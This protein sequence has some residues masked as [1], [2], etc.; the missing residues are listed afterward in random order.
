MKLLNVIWDFIKTLICCVVVLALY[1]GVGS[2]IC[3]RLFLD[4]PQGIIGYIIGAAILVMMLFHVF[5][6]IYA[7]ICLI[8]DAWDGRRKKK[9][10]E[11]E[12]SR[13]DIEEPSQPEPDRSP[14]PDHPLSADELASF[15]VPDAQ[16]SSCEK[17]TDGPAEKEERTHHHHSGC[18]VVIGVLL[19]IAG[20]FVDVYGTW[21]ERS[22]LFKQGV[23][24]YE[25]GDYGNAVQCLSQTTGYARAC[26][27]LGIC[28]YEGKGVEKDWD[29]AFHWFH[30]GAKMED[31]PA[32]DA[33]RDAQYMLGLCFEQAIGTERDMGKALICW[34]KAA[35]LGHAEAQYRVGQTAILEFQEFDDG[36]KYLRQS[37]EQGNPFAM[38]FLGFAYEGKNKAE[39]DDWY[40][41]A[42]A[43]LYKAAKQGDPRAM[44]DLAGLYRDGK[45]VANDPAEAEKWFEQA[46]K[47][48]LALAEQGDPDAQCMIGGFY[49]RGIGVKQDAAEGVKWFRKAAEQ[50]CMKGKAL[51]GL[52]YCEGRGVKQDEAEGVKWLRAAA[53]QGDETSEEFLSEHGN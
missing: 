38:R 48:Y 41:K 43:A 51:L 28:Y 36:V 4:N 47:T 53:E 9:E 19:I 12:M 6:L 31:N 42:A 11:D 22:N 30:E 5:C 50:G 16:E 35:K 17:A 52:A 21:S 27:L 7:G 45:G 18:T 14:D 25:A 26:Y 29:K 44:H 3:Y 32:H 2:F 20:A 13:E 37:A 24:A 33:V 49:A 46:A 34:G 8:K 40:T 39:S 23:A 10:G 1:F 15:S